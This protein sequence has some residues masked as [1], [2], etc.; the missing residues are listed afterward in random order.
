MDD[1]ENKIS[2]T[3][4]DSGEIFAVKGGSLEFSVYNGKPSDFIR[5]ESEI[6][7][8]VRVVKN[9]KMGF[10]FTYS[11]DDISNLTAIAEENLF[12]PDWGWRI[13]K[14]GKDATP[15]EVFDEKYF[16]IG[17]E[18]IF[19]FLKKSE[20]SA[21]G[22]DSR[23]KKS[24]AVSF[25]ASHKEV[26]MANSFGDKKTGK[27][28][29]FSFGIYLVGS[30]AGEVQVG[31]S[32]TSSIRFSDLNFEKIVD[33]AVEDTVSQF[34]AS[35]LP[36]KRMAVLLPPA[37]ACSF[38]SI[39]SGWFCAD[40]FIEGR[41]PPV[42][43]EGAPVAS[44]LLEIVDDG[45]VEGLSGTFPFDGEGFPT[46]RHKIVSG[47]NFTGFLSDTRSARILG[48]RTTANA[49]RDVSTLPAVG[50][51]NLFVENGK[52]PAKDLTSGEVLKIDEVIGLHL[53]NPETGLFSFGARGRLYKG[54]KLQKSVRGITVS[55][56]LTDFFR[57]VVAVGDDLK[58]YSSIGSPSLLVKDIQ[59]SGR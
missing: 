28:T 7:V 57:N 25:S 43:K 15:V 31:G 26:F 1:I 55:G 45:T 23:I 16:S 50:F 34:G 18:E 44:P 53:A 42:W 17:R 54:G 33:E 13:E 12:P 47:G 56:R 10:A 35:S 24:L 8:S 9:G 40:E 58:F 6:G 48:R 39:I 4:F 2:F 36:S 20:L 5:N 3:G 51:F 32:F 59:V 22:K 38:L 41:V 29:L 27:K 21:I 19:E 14:M 30:S 49:Q 52:T 11:G 46:E 37:S